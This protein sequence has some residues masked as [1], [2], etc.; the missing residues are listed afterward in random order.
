MRVEVVDASSCW[1]DAQDMGLLRVTQMNKKDFVSGVALRTGATEEGAD[2]AAVS[3]G[4]VS[5]VAQAPTP[6]QPERP[7]SGQPQL[8]AALT[9]WAAAAAAEAAKAA[10]TAETSTGCLPA[11]QPDQC[12]SLHASRNMD[13]A[14]DFHDKLIEDTYDPRNPKYI[15]PATAQEILE[16]DTCLLQRQL[17]RLSRSILVRELMMKEDPAILQGYQDMLESTRRQLACQQALL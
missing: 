4:A 16:L 8:G 6:H 15:Q 14:S 10:E 13:A 5:A 12:L 17:S 3:L 9:A 7:M 11:T 2:V 1:H